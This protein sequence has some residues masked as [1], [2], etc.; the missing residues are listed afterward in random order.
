M[1]IAGQCAVRPADDPSVWLKAHNVYRCMNGAPPV[2]WSAAA[3]SSAQTY[4]NSITTL[5]H[6]NSYSE[7]PPAGPAGEN[8]AKG[9]QSIEASA[10]GWYSEV[11][12]CATLPGCNNGT[13][14]TGHFTAMVW[15]GVREIGCASNSM[16]SRIDI[17]RYRS[18]DTLG[19]N[20]ANMAGYYTQNVMPATVSAQTCI[21]TI[22]GSATAAPATTATTASASITMSATTTS[23]AAKITASTSTTTTRTTTTSSRQR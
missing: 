18:G 22:E 1:L 16:S 19:P 10:A 5:V 15:L 9:Y 23:R 3:A 13:C 21:A 2:T 11:S 20:T 7:S 14:A 17:C 6:S 8:L 12:C 4:V